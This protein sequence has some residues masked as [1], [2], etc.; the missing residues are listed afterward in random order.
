MSIESTKFLLSTHHKVIDSNKFNFE[1]CRI[2]VNENLNNSYLRFM[3]QNYKDQQLCDFLEFGFP[4]GYNGNNEILQQINKKDVWKFKNHKGAQQFP[5]DMNTYLRKESFNK[6]IIG[7]FK[8]NPFQSGIKIS[9]LNTVPKKDTTERRVILDLS[10][11]KGASLNDFISKDEYLGENIELVYPKVDDFIQLIRQKGQGCFLFK[12]DLKRAFRQIKICPSSYNL[13][14]YVWKKHIFCDCVLPM[15]AKSSAFLC[16][17]FSNAISF[18]LFKIGIYILNYLDDLAS[19]ETPDHAD[20]AYGTLRSILEKCGIEEAKSKACPPSTIMTFIGVLFNTKTMT[21]EV[22]PDRLI[23]LKLLLRQW[24]FKEQASIKEIQSL[25]G[26]LNF[27]AACV[28][29]GRIFISRMLKWLKWLYSKDQKKYH[30]PPYVKKDILWWYKFLPTYNGVSMMLYEEWC[31]PDE[32]FSSDSCLEGCGGFWQGMFF[33]SSFPENFKYSKYN[34]NILEIFSII[35][36]L[37][38]W[39]KFFCQKR[40]QVYCDNFSVVTVINSGKSKCEILQMCLREIAY[41]AAT[42]QFEIR[43]IHLGTNEN[44]IADHL[45]RWNLSEGHRQ[46]FYKLTGEYQLTE[47]VVSKNLFEFIHTW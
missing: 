32:I 25:L 34:I 9:P 31:K 21:I 30:I 39:G 19:A 46:Q 7:P 47:C 38:L 11:P 8:D 28:K 16:Q 4:I 14:A 17:R 24:L 22:T 10:F 13:V 26:K 23:E 18:I 5:E 12:T 36:C 41:I 1:G 15:G 29:P 3:L 27:I 6:A 43:A 37:K 20:F 42:N 35:I 2:P 40:I 44:R 33:H 45:S